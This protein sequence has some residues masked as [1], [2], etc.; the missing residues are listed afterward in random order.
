MTT[1]ER[2]DG[3]ERQVYFR[4]SGRQSELARHLETSCRKLLGADVYVDGEGNIFYYTW[5][6]LHQQGL[7][8]PDFVQISRLAPQADIYA[9]HTR[10]PDRKEMLIAQVTKDEGSVEAAIRAMDHILEG[11]RGKQKKRLEAI[12]HR[13]HEL[14]DLFSGNFDQLTD[15]DLTAARRRTR[16]LLARVGLNPNEINALLHKETQR[17]LVWLDKGSFGHD[18]QNR[19]NK[20]ITA[21]ALS[22]AWRHATARRQ[23]LSQIERKFV[24]AR[25]ALVLER[26]FSR[27]IFADVAAHLRTMSRHDLF[28]K[29]TLTST[30]D[31]PIVLGLLRTMQFQLEQPHVKTYRPL[32]RKVAKIIAEIEALLR[33]NNRRE[34]R[35]KGLFQEAYA[36]LTQELVK[37]RDIYPVKS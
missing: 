19:R 35:Q 24:S 11:T 26:E 9:P 25:E 15:A 2:A 12:S 33:Q 4:R 17:M 8:P 3:R 5:P 18:S 27:A 7:L 30:G 23:G 32:G 31:L 28:H 1:Q 10:Y 20:L 37:Q 29:P 34:I 16:Q 36:L 14:F 6:Q 22:A 21:G 13:A